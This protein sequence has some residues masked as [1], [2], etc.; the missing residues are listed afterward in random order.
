MHTALLRDLSLQNANLK[1]LVH[2]VSCHIL[3]PSSS[4]GG[5]LD[6]LLE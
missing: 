4:E 1:S 3:L 6:V 2:I 5:N